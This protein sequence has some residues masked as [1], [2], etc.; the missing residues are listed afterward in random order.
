MSFSYL[1]HLTFD[2]TDFAGWQSQTGVRTV[3]DTLTAALADLF[4]PGV[5]ATAAGRTD[6]GVHAIDMPVSFATAIDR[7]P[8]IVMRALNATLPPDVKV[9]EARR[10]RD[11]FSAR[12]NAIF[13][14]YRYVIETH[15]FFDPLTRRYAYQIPVALDGTAMQNAVL[16]L[17]GEHDFT[18][19]RAAGCT[20]KSPVRTVIAASV[21]DEGEGR[22]VLSISA[23]GFLRHMVRSI[24]GTLIEIGRHD[25]P[26]EDIDRL[27]AA[28]RRDEAGVT[29]PPQGLFFVRADY[30]E[31][32]F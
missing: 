1:I 15:P 4:E 22:V 7:E 21:A 10:V 11:G 12:R 3:Q 18:S 29:A 28:P 19:F 2:G 8:E 26:V 20:A 23:N 30:P 5:T 24:A 13:R 16:R 9:K 25:R 31:E 17:L 14:A 32:A 27:L 6:A